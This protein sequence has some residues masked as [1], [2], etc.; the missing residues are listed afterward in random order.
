V[1]RSEESRR[2]ATRRRATGYKNPPITTRRLVSLRA[3]R[4]CLAERSEKKVSRRAERESV[5]R[6]E[7]APRRATNDPSECV[8]GR[9]RHRSSAG[10]RGWTVATFSRAGGQA[11]IALVIRRATEIDHLVDARDALVAFVVTDGERLDDCTWGSSVRCV[12]GGHQAL[13]K[14][15]YATRTDV[16]QQTDDRCLLL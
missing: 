15:A 12:S 5:P 11:F 8:V 4:E 16:A 1:S 3:K 13:V 6:S 9:A 14:C 7:R 2:E 10:I